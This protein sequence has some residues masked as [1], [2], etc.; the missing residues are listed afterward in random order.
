MCVNKAAKQLSNNII[1]ILDQYICGCFNFQEGM[2]KI[3]F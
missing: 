2:H 3:I 1:S